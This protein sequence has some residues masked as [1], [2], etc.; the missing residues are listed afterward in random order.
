MGEKNDI[1]RNGITHLRRVVGLHDAQLT[2]G[3]GIRGRGRESGKQVENG[4]KYRLVK[5]MRSIGKAAL[6]C[7]AWLVCMMLKAE[8]QDLKAQPYSAAAFALAATGEDT[9]QGEDY[10]Q[11]GTKALDER[12]WGKALEAF[13]E[14]IRLKGSRADGALYWKA[15]A[16]NKLGQR[17]DALA[18]IEKL[19]KDF[20]GS[21]WLKDAKALE[22][23]IR[24]ASGQAVAPEREADED[25]KLMAL[26]SLQN[27]DPERAL[28]LLEKI[29]TGN[30]PP[31]VKER[32]LFVLA[33][34][35]SPQ[36]RD[37]LAQ[38]AKGNA[39]PDVQMK[40]LNYL[41]LFGGK[42]SRQILSDIYASSSN[43]AV[44]RA[45][46]HSF[47]VGGDK[48]RLLAAAR[49]EKVP[50]LR[51]EAIQQLGVL[52]ASDSLTELYRTETS[53]EV[54]ET[55]IHALMVG[56]SA[57]RIIDLARNEKDPKLRLSAIHMLGVMG[58]AKTADTLVSMYESDKDASVRKAVIAG[59]FVQGNAKA[60]I[61]L[62]KKETDPA[63]KKEIVSRL[64]VMDSKEAT[65]YLMEILNK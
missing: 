41:G 10:Y 38:I 35:G 37:F 60:L 50:E 63:M 57:D 65:D 39:A 3:S 26:N 58:S 44:K 30:Q 32:A 23:E 16:Q 15:Y 42:E 52:G 25:L 59:L 19:R 56:G 55:I 47:M 36:A 64:S 4:V 24:Q 2:Q 12:Q 29:L 8:A 27:S 11:Q 18:A 33:Q 48:D 31:K 14:V 46:L 45:I 43:N 49:T 20:P 5:K 21:S 40:A 53:P 51:R 34:S 22:L 7:S 28:P 9:S 61:A 17:T 1:D 13:N 6:I 62:A 54:K